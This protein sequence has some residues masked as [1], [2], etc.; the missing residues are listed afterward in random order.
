[1]IVELVPLTAGM[2]AG[3][4]AGEL[5]A[6]FRGDE[7]AARELLAETFAHLE[8]HPRPDP[9]G[10]YL[11]R[12]GGAFVGACAFKGAPDA[13]GAVEIAYTTFP[14]FERRGH[15]AATIAALTDLAFTAGA[16]LVVAHTL[17]EE[18]ASNRGLR[19][20]GFTF[21]GDVVDP[22]DGPVWRWE[23]PAARH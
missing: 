1:M 20:N 5:A 23:K 14:A 13:Q 11:V 16:P 22:E 10:S 2:D 9:W 4:T 21:A 15:A 17:P 7:A 3:R 12:D 8:R 6:G 18:N 19:R